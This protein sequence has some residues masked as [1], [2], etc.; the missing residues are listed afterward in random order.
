MA[1]E[2]GWEDWLNLDAFLLVI[3]YHVLRILPC[4]NHLL[5]PTIWEVGKLFP[6]IFFVNQSLYILAIWM[7]VTAWPHAFD[8][9]V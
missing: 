2:V 6:G 4:V 3:V 5:R 1:S 9:Y 8:D 7:I